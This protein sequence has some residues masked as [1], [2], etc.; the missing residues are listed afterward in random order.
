MLKNQMRDLG[1]IFSQCREFQSFISL[2][3][4]RKINIMNDPILGG[5]IS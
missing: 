4:R 3:M 1:Y 5:I 2:A